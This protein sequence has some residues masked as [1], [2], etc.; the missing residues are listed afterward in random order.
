[1]DAAASIFHAGEL[2]IQERVGVR[3]QMAGAAAYIRDF[4]PEQHREFYHSLPF[5]FVGALDAAGQPWATVLAAD[6][7]FIVTPDARTLDIRSG[8]LP[9]DPLEGQLRAGD[10]IGGLGLEPT[11]RRRNRRQ[12]RNRRRRRWRVARERDAKLRQL[13]A[14]HPAPPAQS[15]AG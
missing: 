14:V 11:T 2:A 9:G 5:F 15:G 4:M 12:W 1:M 7:G 13:P 8:M 6:P 3:E 10:H